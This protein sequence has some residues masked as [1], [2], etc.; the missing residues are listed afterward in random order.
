MN[1]NPP[2][3]RPLPKIISA[4]EIMQEK[5]V[6]D[7]LDQLPYGKFNTKAKEIEAKIRANYKAQQ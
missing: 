3:Q 1:M 2:L 7:A 5:A 6:Q 4:K